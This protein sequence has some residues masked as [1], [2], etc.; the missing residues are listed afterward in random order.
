MLISAKNLFKTFIVLTV[1]A[2][3]L[4]SPFAPGNA[5]AEEGVPGEFFTKEAPIEINAD[6]LSYNKDTETY[7]ASGNVVIVQE[8]TTL[9][10]DEAVMDMA[11]GIA[12]A[13]GSVLIVDEGGNTLKGDNLVFDIKAKTAVVAN[14]RL[15]YKE[16][17]IH[18]AGDVIRKIGPQTYASNRVT[19]TSCDC[20]EDETPSWDFSARRARVTVGE[21]LTGRHAVFHVKGV[22]VAYSP[23]F[24]VPIKRG[25]QTGFLTP[26]PGF[27]TLRGFG[28]AVPFFWAISKSQDA[29]FY[30]DVQTRRGFGGGAEY[31]YIRSRKSFGEVYFYY[32]K[33]KDIDRVREFR[34]DTDNLSR[35]LSATD[36][37]WEFRLDHTE[38]LPYGFKFRADLHLVSDDEFLLDFGKT[39]DEKSIESLE[40][41]VSLSKNWSSY[42]LVVQF[43]TFDNL[44]LR[45]D[46]TTL[47]KFPE[48]T[49]S[50]SD[51]QILGSRVYVSLSSS[52]INF[53][54]EEGV[55][56]SRL[57]VRP[58]F[59]L[60][61]NPG[62]YFDLTPSLTPR[63][64]FYLVKD[65]PEGRYADRYIYE[66]NVDLTT[67]F[68]RI[69]RT[70]I[71]AINAV[72]HTLRPK[73]TY[74][75]IPE[76]VQ[77]DL[78]QFDA[79][80]AI[81]AT[82]RLTYSLN[83][84]FTGRAFRDGKAKYQEYVYMDISQS[85]D[86]NE[87]TRKTTS[88]AEERRPFSDVSGEIILRPTHWS[89]VTGRASYNVY[90]DWFASYD[91]ELELSSGRGDYLR[92]TRRFVRATLSYFEASGRLKATKSIDLTYAKRFS[93]D[94]DRSLETSYGVEYKQQCWTAILGYTA[95]LEE[96][97]IYLTFDLLSLGRI[98]GAQAQIDS[99]SPTN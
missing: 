81:A 57:D 38:L 66:A 32:F 82:N 92:L 72:K 42:N 59:S 75:Y 24:R 78:P 76:A 60:P 16:E 96:K 37:R 54:R 51:R 48:V 61:L 56:G 9:S 98:A 85:F 40:S 1:C 65:R 2:L 29:T 97:I 50:A 35:P 39:S 99:T 34:D 62:G 31:R 20:D 15:F 83:T 19:Y 43:R 93:F 8:N 53:A 90:D 88:P 25:R 70:S 94:E 13:T 7:F 58:S 69:Y 4:L 27:S 71:I 67:T 23:F 77:S 87:S 45:D 95:R 22:P 63:G 74:T 46:S 30:L 21:F 41:N 11:A 18:I 91:S 68:V 36:K 3:A 73:L 52:Y 84:T 47:K 89:K 55:H 10:S 33:E 28:I 44:L 6:R 26:R 14:A 12:T 17:N 5:L 79:V 80:D 86:I 64:T 49:F